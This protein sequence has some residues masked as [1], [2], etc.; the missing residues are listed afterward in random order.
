MELTYRYKYYKYYGDTL[1]FN[2]T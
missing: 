1:Q 2:K